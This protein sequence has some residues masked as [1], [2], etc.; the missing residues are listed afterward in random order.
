M[1]LGIDFDNTIVCYDKVFHQI[2]FK[3]NL[4]PAFVP[5]SKEHVRNYLRQQGHEQAWTE[6]Q[7]GVYGSS[8]QAADP[9]P[10]VLDF[11][12]QCAKQN[13]AIRI[14]SHKT[15][16][17]KYD[18]THSTNLRTAALEWMATQHF[19]DSQGLGLSQTDVLFGETRPE[20]VGHI[21]Q[22]GCTHFIDDLEEVFLEETFPV[23]VKKFLFTPN[24][25]SKTLSGVI[26]MA[27]WQEISEHFFGTSV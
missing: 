10:G 1:L 22:S 21:R 26:T 13:I 12:S 23:H 8:I 25:K 17:A 14:I 19:F 27:S 15:K 20:K 2:A 18:L 6:L 9:F 7:G 3:K 16:F 24:D 4:I 11:L 5:V